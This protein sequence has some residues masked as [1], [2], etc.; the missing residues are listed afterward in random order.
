[1]FKSDVK[2]QQTNSK[3]ILSMILT[4]LTISIK[5]SGAA[6]SKNTSFFMG[7]DQ[8]DLQNGI[9]EYNLDIC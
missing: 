3:Q 8:R 6:S 4:K 7:I 2:H 9:I 5:S 1:M